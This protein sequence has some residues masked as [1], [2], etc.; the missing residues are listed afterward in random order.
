MSRARRQFH[1]AGQAR[2][3]AGPGP[4]KKQRG[5]DGA[6][7]LKDRVG[8]QWLELYS[9]V[10]PELEEAIAKLG[11]HVKCPVHGGTDGFRLFPDAATT[12][13]GICSTCQNSAGGTGFSD[14]IAVL[15]W[16]YGWSFQEATDVIGEWLGDDLFP[17]ERVVRSQEPRRRLLGPAD[18]EP[19]DDEMAAG[20]ED[21]N[22]P[23][24]DPQAVATIERIIDVAEPGHARVAAYWQHRGLSVAPPDT[25]AFV[26]D[27]RYYFD[28]G[29]FVTMPAMVAGVVSP[30]GTPVAIFRTFLDL[31]GDGKALVD[32]P[33]KLTRAIYPGATKGAAIRLRDP[34]EGLVG[35]AE[36][37][38][39][40]EAVF[41]GA[42]MPCWA[43]VS[44]GGV[45]RFVPPAGITRVVV[46]SDNDGSGVGQVAANKLAN[47]LYR[48]GVPVSVAVPPNAGTDWLEM[49]LADGED[50]LRR[51]AEGAPLLDPNVPGAPPAD[52]VF[53]L[54]EKPA[55]RGS[56]RS[57]GRP[58]Q[59]A[60]AQGVI[61]QAIAKLNKS[62]FVVQIGGKTHVI[63]VVR[64]PVT[65]HLELRFGS[66]AD[67]QLLHQPWR[68]P[69]GDD[70]T[71]AAA[72]LW[73]GSKDRRQFQGI[74]FS[75]AGDVPG[76]F[77]TWQGFAVEPRPG[78]CC[79]FW[80][81]LFFVICRGDRKHYRYLRRWLAHMV[82]RPWELPGVAIVVIGKQGTGK[83]TFTDLLGELVGPH[84]LVLTS[85]EQLVGRF[86]GHLRDRLLV[87]ANEAVWAGSKA[88]EGALKAMI[89]DAVVP[90]EQKF[91]DLYN[92]RNT[93]RLVIT[94]NKP[95]AAPMEADDRRYLVLAAADQRKGDVA[96]FAAL[97]DQ[98]RNRGG[99]QA[100]LHDL[101]REDLTGFDVRTKPASTYAFDIKLRSGDPIVRWWYERLHGGVLRA[102]LDDLDTAD[103]HQTPVRR[104]LHADFMA[105]CR[106][107]G[108]RTLD[109]P[110]FGKELRKVLPGLTVGETRPRTGGTDGT[111][112]RPHCYVL[113]SL[114]EC[115]QAFEEYMGA[116][117]E[118]WD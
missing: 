2:R 41:Q 115:R 108:A 9:D 16:L 61:A 11:R 89:T 27:E 105:F 81:H 26:A 15:Q 8:D 30:D 92:V 78:N 13:G 22:D 31:E 101:L 68:V 45:E 85:M 47:R 56:R 32:Q 100:L 25:V 66:K 55:K 93:K 80:Q 79:L 40:A 91:V 14:G 73:L 18:T 86:T 52:A 19:G 4:G 37:I 12:G 118:I 88:G 107:H 95:W 43:A 7:A 58:T 49:L 48:Q 20:P 110:T 28:D 38:E 21:G 3:G 116:G 51:A 117:P 29:E 69:V 50:A 71:E 17:A 76:W 42:G 87:V 104:M 53:P 59:D 103:W 33:K 5:R 99:L 60:A 106:D 90:V 70:R 23:T 67:F 65:G 72:D 62:H 114:A 96:Y 75:P 111:V 1:T 10:A 36:G 82:Q 39:T 83:G 6:A 97:H 74:I 57:D 84:F 63:T 35:L 102:G 112:T 64:D 54:P 94:T 98:M 34:A 109:E 24:P 77:N 113:P 46:W 44:A